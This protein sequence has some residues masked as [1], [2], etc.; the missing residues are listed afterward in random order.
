L[1]GGQGGC[2]KKDSPCSSRGSDT[3]NNGDCVILLIKKIFFNIYIYI[4]NGI[5]CFYASNCYERSNV[6][7]AFKDP[8]PCG[9]PENGVEAGFILFF[10]FLEE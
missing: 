6:C 7:S 4:W 5:D 8:S 1:N 2:E 3:C 10:F 9:S